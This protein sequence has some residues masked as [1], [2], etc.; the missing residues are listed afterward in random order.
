MPELKTIFTGDATPL[1]RELKNIPRLTEKAMRDMRGT[2]ETH[3]KMGR[4][5]GNAQN[6]IFN[7]KG[8][9]DAARDY[10]DWWSKALTEQDVKA[11]TRSNQARR[12]LRQREAARTR[13][14]EV[15]A[16]NATDAS[17]E[18]ASRSNL[19]RRLLR[20]RAQR[21]EARQK[22]VFDEI[23]AGNIPENMR[24]AGAA[25]A[26][27]RSGR[28]RVAS[29]MFVSVARDTAASLGS[30]ADP[31]TVFLQQAPQVA[32]AAAMIG[33][34]F[35]ALT[36]IIGGA[37][38]A[39][40]GLG[41]ALNKVVNVI[42]DTDNVAGAGLEKRR[43]GLRKLVEEAESDRNAEKQKTAA[44]LDARK[45]LMDA[46]QEYANLRLK[47]RI[48]NAPNEDERHRLTNEALQEDLGRA[49]DLHQQLMDQGI[50][51]S[52]DP[53]VRRRGTIAQMAVEAAKQAIV[54]ENQRHK[55]ALDSVKSA[56]PTKS[57]RAAD[58]N[59]LQR[60]GGMAV[61]NI[62]M[63]DIARGQLARLTSIDQKLSRG[64][65]GVNFGGR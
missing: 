18:A 23:S 46:E 17:V 22:E 32:Q 34:R 64:G 6:T 42:Y 5:T 25:A 4:T 62:Q 45:K 44:D 35:L 30:G 52:R 36:G 41:L 57:Q 12:L 1:Q 39:T 63:L 51:D 7:P 53:S 55:S 14:E 56:A 61:G 33:G 49:Q 13:A 40:L 50:F 60:I 20:E 8:Q 54:E 48:A 37:T 2:L 59:E 43:L 16:Q 65:R 47:N 10:G 27:A 26:A 24:G 11:A 15:A 19:A 9:A 29:T 3:F 58:A 31:A 38:L 21:K 28:F